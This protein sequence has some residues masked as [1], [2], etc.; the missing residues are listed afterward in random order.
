VWLAIIVPLLY[1]AAIGLAREFRRRTLM[2]VGW[3][4][5]TAGVLVLLGHSI[6]ISQVPASVVSDASLRPAA[7]AAIATS[8]L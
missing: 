8:M 6:L 5:V 7:A 4:M 2:S 1:A 3:G